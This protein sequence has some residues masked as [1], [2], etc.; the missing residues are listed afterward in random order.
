MG[1]NLK[2]RI[3]PLRDALVLSS[4]LVALICFNTFLLYRQVT[5]AFVYQ[6]KNYLIGIAHGVASQIDGDAHE[7]L[8]SADQEATP[9]YQDLISP[10]RKLLLSIP[11][12]KYI[13]STTIKDGVTY[14][15]LDAALPG[16]SD[17]DGV[18]DHSY[19]WEIYPDVDPDM[20]MALKDNRPVVSRQPY[21]DKWGTFYSGH[22]PIYN[23]QGKQ[24]G[25]AS[26][27]ILASRFQ[28]QLAELQRK[29]LSAV[30][31]PLLVSIGVGFGVYL[32]RKSAYQFELQRKRDL[33]MLKE[34]QARFRIL[35]DS[36][37]IMI[38][39]SNPDGGRSFFNHRWQNF[40]GR[41]M[42][43]ELGDGWS[44]SVHTEDLSSCLA[45]YRDAIQGKKNYEAEFRLKRSDGEY[46]RV[47]ELGV[48]RFSI[49]GE[50]LGMVGTTT[51]S[52]D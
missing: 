30:I 9:A 38:W 37:P 41:K 43:H 35:A 2:F 12:V 18:D 20:M 31:P 19:L 45:A 52:H 36:A 34:S 7:R 22:V 40:T 8:V 29:V 3:H 48:P 4:L 13:Y 24:V 39:M 25:V 32:L 17:Q 27:D 49:G 50:F 46:R 26:V 44:E 16:D 10:L 11:D 33:E 28:Q 15:I 51:V 6:F 1:S 42:L 21:Q 14:F 47:S 23:A 5:E